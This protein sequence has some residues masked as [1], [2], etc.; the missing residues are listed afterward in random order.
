MDDDAVV[1][2][3]VVVNVV[4]DDVVVDDVAVDDEDAGLDGRPARTN[5][6][7]NRPGPPRL[8]A[9]AKANLDDT[10]CRRRVRWQR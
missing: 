3:A 2:D 6:V 4:V 1:D 8:R 5:A 7:E 9:A 10:K